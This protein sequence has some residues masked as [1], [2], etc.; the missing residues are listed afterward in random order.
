MLQV[1]EREVTLVEKFVFL[2]ANFPMQFVVFQRVGRQ[3]IQRLSRS[4]NSKPPTSYH[5]PY[6]HLAASTAGEVRFSQAKKEGR[7]WRFSSTTRDPRILHCSRA[8]GC[9]ETCSPD[10]TRKWHQRQSYFEKRPFDIAECGCALVRSVASVANTPGVPNSEMM[11]ILSG[12][13]LP[14]RSSIGIRPSSG[15]FH[16]P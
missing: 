11:Y 5:L 3:L 13:C 8:T 10:S 2:I 7:R 4:D 1:C 16:A 6:F 12:N 15:P 14:A 9:G